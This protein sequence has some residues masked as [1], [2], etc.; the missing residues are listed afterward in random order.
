[1]KIINIYYNFLAFQNNIIINFLLIL[2]VFF[3]IQIKNKLIYHKNK[4]DGYY[5]YLLLSLNNEQKYNINLLNI[6]VNLYDKM[7]II[8]FCLV[9]L[10]SNKHTKTF[11]LLLCFFLSFYTFKNI[12]YFRI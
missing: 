8:F 11:Y 5:K 9:L 10:L 2:N 3:P 1:M 12:I 6:D 7:K 4:G